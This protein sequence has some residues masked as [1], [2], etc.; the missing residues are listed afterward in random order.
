MNMVALRS[1]LYEPRLKAPLV[2]A[3]QNRHVRKA[4]G[5]KLPFAAA[6]V[7]VAVDDEAR[8]NRADAFQEMRA[9]AAAHRAAAFGN[10]VAVSVRRAVDHEDVRV[11]GDQCPLAFQVLRAAVEGPI[12]EPGLPGRAPDLEPLPFRAGVLQIR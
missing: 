4:G 7:D 2:I 6:F 10:T 8:L 3:V 5:A 11:V 12:E 9:A 1:K